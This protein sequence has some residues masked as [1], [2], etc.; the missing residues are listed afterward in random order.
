MKKNKIYVCDD[1]Y[2]L[3]FFDKG[4]FISLLCIK[5]EFFHNYKVN[6]GT[7]DYREATS[8]EIKWL[9]ACEKANKFIPLQDINI[10]SLKLFKIL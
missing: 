1:N 5:D 10:Q 7:S 8:N 6:F 9:E 4:V 2:I 3:R